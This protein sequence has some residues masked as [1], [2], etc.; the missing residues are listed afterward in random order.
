MIL[1]T[2]APFELEQLVPSEV[3]LKCDIC[4]RFPDSGTPLSPFF[5]AEEISALPPGALPEKSFRE[6][7]GGKITLVPFP[8][9]IESP[10]HQEGFICPAFD[11]SSQTCGIY[12]LRPFDCRLYPFML[13]QIG[14]EVVLGKDSKCPYITD[15]M[16]REKI[17][18]YGERVVALLRAPSWKVFILKNR[19][20]VGAD[21]EDVTT[22]GVLFS[23]KG[24]GL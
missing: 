11:P 15:P 22:I 13:M 20:L 3:C 19:G 24:K 4:C 21:Q 16:N 9:G 17:D 2:G 12:S 6:R 10:G 7:S 5:T 14:D 8:V 1:N 18:A 23:V